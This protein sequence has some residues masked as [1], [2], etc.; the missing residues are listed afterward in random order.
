[1]TYKSFR[2]F[3]AAVVSTILLTSCGGHTHTGSPWACD[4]ENHWQV[5]QCGE[6]VSRAA[7]TLENEVCTVCGSDVVR[8]DDGTGHITVYD[9]HGNC[10]RTTFYAADG[11]MES[12][13]SFVYQ[14]D[15]NGSMQSMQ[16]HVN[17]IFQSICTYLPGS[18]GES[19][20]NSRT[21]YF[22]DGGRRYEGYDENGYLLRDTT[23]AADGNVESDLQYSYNGDYSRMFEKQY[24]G[25]MLMQEYEYI[26]DEEGLQTT[27]KGITY[28]DDG[29][30]YAF[31]YDDSGNS[32]SE[33]YYNA[34]GSIS[35]ELT[36][37][38]EY[39]SEG[40]L[41]LVRTFD[42]GVLSREVEYIHGSDG[43]GEW[44][45]SGKTIDY[46]PDGT[47]VI[48]ESAPDG[49]WSSEIACAADGSILNEVR[50]ESEFDENGES[51]GV[52][53]YEN[54]RLFTES[55]P[56][57]DDNGQSIGLFIAEYAP[58]GSKTVR[59]Y[60]E[61]FDLVNTLQYDPAGNIT[62]N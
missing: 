17:G 39:D 50:Y 11:S 23:H 38:N 56:L 42:G 15:D 57:Y 28:N 35:Q 58:D 9:E 30:S 4:F 24:I 20:M 62:E 36:Y 37:E 21:E 18:D 5:C 1:M 54:G 14:Y 47:K 32:L 49:T 52:K 43:D 33:T 19:Y 59:K 10:I 61:E 34:D 48:N 44:S 22:E 45:M 29:T 46:L 31:A 51:I 40:R 60:N 55:G 7:H 13:E 27:I 41:L 8:Y 12:K 53:G 2:I 26:V 3:L 16:S 25:D 6:E